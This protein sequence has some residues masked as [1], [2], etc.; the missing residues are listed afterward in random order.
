MNP[1]RRASVTSV[2]MILVLVPSASA[3]V[4]G[5]GGQT[6][7]PC[8]RPS[9]RQIC[10]R[11]IIGRSGSLSAACAH[12]LEVPPGQCGLRGFGQIQFIAFHTFEIRTP[13]QPTSY[14]V[15]VPLDSAIVVTSIGSPE[16]DR[17]PPRS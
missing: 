5:W 8:S 17:G 6:A 15:S 1:L 4:A 7:N 9:N 2:L 10:P 13:F 11:T 14:K 3:C 12:L 16:T